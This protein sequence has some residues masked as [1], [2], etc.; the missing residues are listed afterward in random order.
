MGTLKG[1]YFLKD[2]KTK[3]PGVTTILSRFKESGGLIHWAWKLGT[4]GKDYREVRDSAAS[5]GT[6]A[7]EAV[8]AWIHDELITDQWWA[9]KGGEA[10][11][12]ERAK[13]SFGAFLEW[14]DQ[15]QLKVDETECALVSEDHKYGGTP[16]AFT[17][18]GK[19]AVL[20]W[21]TSGRLYPEYLIQIAAYGKLWEENHPNDPI[22]GGFHLLRFDK[23]YGD[24][25]HHFW[26]ELNT[27]W[28]AFLHLRALY[29]CDKELKRRV[30]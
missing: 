28:A 21:K 29:E 24:F 30:L 27:A 4:E 1:G 8:E 2:G 18:K 25:H 19:R 20:D 6:M 10:T 15:T 3:V 16:D 23:E 12:V 7:H 22:V 11:I 14:A 26:T 5:A 13:K 9:L 17:I